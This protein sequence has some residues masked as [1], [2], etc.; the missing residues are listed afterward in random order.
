[1]EKN[2]QY[3]PITPPECAV[4][5]LANYVLSSQ[6]LANNAPA[7]GVSLNGVRFILSSPVNLPVANQALEFSVTGSAFLY[8]SSPYTNNNGIVD[9][10]ARNFEP[11]TVQLFANLVADETVSANSLLT[12][13]PTGPVPTYELTS[14]IIVNDAPANGSSR[15]EVEFYLSYGGTGVSGQLR[16]YFNGA[17]TELVTTAPTGF[18][19]ASF[20]STEP[21]TF[22]V[23]AEVE[24][25]RTV[26]ASET[27]SFSP[28]IIYPIRLGSNVITF[29]RAG[30]STLAGIQRFMAGFNVIEGH[31]YSFE[32]SPANVFNYSVCPEGSVFDNG[33]QS[34]LL[35]VSSDYLHLGNG[36]S[37]VRALTSGQG[38]SLRSRYAVYP[39]LAQ[40]LTFNIVVYDNGPG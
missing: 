15:N 1:M 6:I 19:T 10:V 26:F 36:M 32:I 31:V 27:V 30:A 38:S 28:V 4:S 21:G 29:P 2:K 9:V 12:F 35:G 37:P 22:T 20:G 24:N 16:L 18:Y 7:D 8:F 17:F 3:Y 11:E 39:A 33:S 34:C 5:P 40:Y 13:I 23:T 14:R 25:D